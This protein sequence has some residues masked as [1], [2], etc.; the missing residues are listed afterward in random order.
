MSSTNPFEDF[1][2]HTTPTTNPFDDPPMLIE[3]DTTTPFG[4]DTQTED[5]DMPEDLPVEASWQYLGD[6][7]YRRIPIYDNISWNHQGLA[8]IS[9][10]TMTMKPHKGMDTREWLT[11]STT[12]KGTCVYVCVC[13]HVCLGLC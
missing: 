4:G 6:L 3:N 7:P 1:R 12:T 11:T 8:A 2:I 10:N 9:V 5:E 13:V